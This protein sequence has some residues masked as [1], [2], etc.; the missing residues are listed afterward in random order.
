MT[1]KY[2]SYLSA[3]VTG[4]VFPGRRNV[5]GQLITF[6]NTKRVKVEKNSIIWSECYVL[7]NIPWICLYA[8]PPHVLVD[9]VVLPLGHGS[10]V[11]E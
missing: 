7:A 10:S 9:F 5:I 4:F 6:N 2:Y 8:M 1:S 3:D 11:T